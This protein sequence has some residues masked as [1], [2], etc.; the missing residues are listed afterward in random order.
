MKQ[1]KVDLEVKLSGLEV[2]AL[3]QNTSSTVSWRLLSAAECQ[4]SDASRITTLSSASS[5]S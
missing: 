2:S 3:D 1:C 5:F 4:H